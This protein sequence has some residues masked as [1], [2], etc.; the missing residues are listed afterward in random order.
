MGIYHFLRVL[1]IEM[2]ILKKLLEKKRKSSFISLLTLYII[3][4]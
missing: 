1:A 2:D 4:V 3:N